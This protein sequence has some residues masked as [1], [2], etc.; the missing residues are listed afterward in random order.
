MQRIFKRC[1][2]K[3]TFSQMNGFVTDKLNELAPS[4]IRYGFVQPGLGTSAIWQIVSG[5]LVQLWFRPADHVIDFQAFM[6]DQ[7]AL[8]VKNKSAGTRGGHPAAVK[9][10]SDTFVF[11]LP[12]PTNRIY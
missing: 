11:F 3:D 6:N 5:F 2:G 8:K 9:N 12:N 7:I 4:G 10:S 1:N